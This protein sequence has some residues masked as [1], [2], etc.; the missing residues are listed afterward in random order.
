MEGDADPTLLE[1]IPEP[2]WDYIISQDLMLSD[3]LPLPE[4]NSNGIESYFTSLSSHDFSE[5]GIFTHSEEIISHDYEIP[6]IVSHDFIGNGVPIVSSST[7]D[8]ENSKED[9]NLLL[10]TIPEHLQTSQVFESF[11]SAHLNSQLIQKISNSSYGHDGVFLQKSKKM[12]TE[13]EFTR[14]TPLHVIQ[15][16]IPMKKSKTTETKPCL[17]DKNNSGRRK[18]SFQLTREDGIVFYDVPN[19]GTPQRHER[20]MPR[21]LDDSFIWINPGEI[22]DEPKSP[23]SSTSQNSVQCSKCDG[24]FKNVSEHVC[25]KE[26]EIIQES[27]DISPVVVDVLENVTETKLFKCSICMESFEEGE[28][29]KTHLDQHANGHRF[30]CEICKKK[31][32]KLHKN[33]KAHQKY[34]SRRTE[35]AKSDSDSPETT[36]RKIITRSSLK[37]KTKL[38]NT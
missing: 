3:N 18:Q 27:D 33:L 13:S 23:S 32:Y 24:V 34:C 28:S 30:Q 25:K 37:L 22:S 14:C 4:L 1:N 12:S 20:H 38:K 2:D 17:G 7:T 9:S 6:E 11:P 35:E 26:N 8:E 5:I 15:E 21:V 16:K 31:T 36:P 29:L 10:I 19:V